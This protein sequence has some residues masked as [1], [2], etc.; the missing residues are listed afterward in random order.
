M[1]IKTLILGEKEKKT[2]PNGKLRQQPKTN[3]DYR[4]YFS[5]F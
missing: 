2:G 5:L 4:N 3:H 1:Q